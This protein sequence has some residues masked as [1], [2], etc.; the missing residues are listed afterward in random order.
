M[1]YIN[2]RFLLQ[3]QTGVNRFAYE[4]CKALLELNVHFVLL[5]PP[6]RIM[7]CY[8][9]SHFKIQI[10]GWGKSHL[11]EQISLPLYWIGL[12]GKKLL[13]NFTGIGPV[14]IK[15]KIMT[16]HDMGLWVTPEWYSKVYVTL[17]KILTPLSAKTSIKVIT[18]SQFSKK[19]IE[20][21]LKIDS[22]KIEVVYNAVPS[23]FMNIK[24]DI[25]CPKYNLEKYVLT[26]S[27]IDPRKN[28]E[29]LVNAFSLLD[30]ESVKLYIIGGQNRIFNNEGNTKNTSSIKWLGRV[31][32]EE[33]RMYYRNAQAFIYPSLYEGFGIPAIEAME[34][35]C[36]I[37]VSDIPVMHEVCGDAALYIDPYSEE[38]M[39][40]G[41]K[42][43]L[44]NEELREELKNK[45]R[46]Q[47]RFYSWEK[48]AQKLLS[49]IRN[50]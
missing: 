35:D 49:I 24:D 31:S 32:D 29:R 44:L 20:R 21:L 4:L 11:W 10:C 18:V 46:K 41:I 30:E 1:L 33:L 14:A 48:S 16:I 38:D 37:I 2:G 39:A 40:Q 36:P 8:D 28:F 27:S 23:F 19:E 42:A 5:C 43:I 6:G 3:N 45:A 50:I 25:M 9:V 22:T 26:V 13:L 15:N 7:S 47:L 17:Y 34:L 12:K